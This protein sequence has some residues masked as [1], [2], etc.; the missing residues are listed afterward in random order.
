MGL[1]R[2]GH[3]WVTELNW[4]II[5]SV[6]HKTQ[7][8]LNKPVCFTHAKV[9]L[10]YVHETV[11]AWKPAFLQDSCQSFYGPGQLPL[12]QCYLKMHDVDEGPGAI[13]WVLRHF[14]SLISRLLVTI[15]IF[16]V[17]Q[18]VKNL[19]AMQETWVR[20]LGQKDPLEKGMTHPLQYSCLENPMD[21]GAWQAAV[22]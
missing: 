8:W 22:H 9:L 20:S 5:K 18:T 10:S 21:R 11:F 14:L 17:A 15:W 4:I 13:L 6:L 1:Q 3:D 7:N 19:P 12:C 16:P 2:V